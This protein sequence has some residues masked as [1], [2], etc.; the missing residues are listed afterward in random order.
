MCGSKKWM[1]RSSRNYCE[2]A[3]VFASSLWSLN[4]ASLFVVMIMKSLPLHTANCS[5][6]RTHINSFT[7]PHWHMHMHT[8][9]R[10]HTWVYPLTH[11]HNNPHEYTLNYKDAKVHIL[12]QSRRQIDIL[13]LT[14]IHVHTYSHIN[15]THKPRHE[16]TLKHT[17]SHVRVTSSMTV[18]IIENGINDLSSNPT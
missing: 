17:H 4:T 7:Q 14:Y 15:F 18:I 11:M 9:S 6:T 12:T 8:H 3:I 5:L 13:K 1:K 2:R 10:T 16:N